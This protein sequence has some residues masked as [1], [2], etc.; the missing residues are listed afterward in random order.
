M[1][2][3]DVDRFKLLRGDSMTDQYAAQLVAAL[4]GIRNELQT[5][6]LGVA[7]LIKVQAAGAALQ[8]PRR[9]GS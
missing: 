4:Q 8:T 1:E 2:N 7:E 3:P 6:N 5:L 9:P